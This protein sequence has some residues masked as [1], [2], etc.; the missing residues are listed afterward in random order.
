[1]LYV[2][3][4]KNRKRFIKYDNNNN[5]TEQDEKVLKSIKTKETQQVEKASE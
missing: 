3:L 5:G 2:Q 1:M 4:I